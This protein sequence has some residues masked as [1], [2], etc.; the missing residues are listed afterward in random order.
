MK[1]KIK[2]KNKEAIVREYQNQIKLAIE[3]IISKEEKLSSQTKEYIKNLEGNIRR[4]PF[5]LG[6]VYWPEKTKK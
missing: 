6:L 5:V 3:K 4:A 2:D 1:Y